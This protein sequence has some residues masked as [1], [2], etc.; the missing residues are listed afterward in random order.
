M[1]TCKKCELEKSEEEFNKWY[2]KS[3]ASGYRTNCK[4][5]DHLINKEFRENNKDKLRINRRKRTGAQPKRYCTDPIKRKRNEDMYRSQRKFPEKR[6][7]R[8]FLSSYI[9]SGKIVKPDTCDKCLKTGRVE[10]HHDDY[11]K[12][13]EVKWLCKRCHT[14]IHW[15]S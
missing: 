15:K 10:G 9:R 14:D 13:L 8:Q 6:A 7:A 11:T 3:G 5:C 4:S 2:K 12:P 1:K